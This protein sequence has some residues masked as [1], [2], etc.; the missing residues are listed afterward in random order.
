MKRVFGSM[1]AAIL[2]IVLVLSLAACGNA[3]ESKL[4]ELDGLVTEYE[5][6]VANAQVEVDELAYYVQHYDIISYEEI[7]VP[8][9]T[10][11]E[12]LTAQKDEI[13]SAYKENRDS[14]TSEKLDELIELLSS[15]IEVGNKFVDNLREMVAKAEEA[16]NGT[17]E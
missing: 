8:I 2:V 4:E 15:Q 1:A 3:N 10:T 13:I 12:E 7:F 6:I 11:M 16:V 14:Y 17:V 5:G 9:E